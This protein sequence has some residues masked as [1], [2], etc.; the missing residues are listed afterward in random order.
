MSSMAVAINGLSETT[1]GVRLGLDE[2]V[3]Q[4]HESTNRVNEVSWHFRGRSRSS[5]R[6]AVESSLINKTSIHDKQQHH[7]NADDDDNSWN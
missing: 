7:N 1:S 3:A 6:R 4:I 5:P 2:I